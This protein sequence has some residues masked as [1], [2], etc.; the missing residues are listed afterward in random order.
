MTNLEK[1]RSLLEEDMEFFESLRPYANKVDV[2]EFISNN[3]EQFPI[4]CE[5]ITGK[6]KRT[7][8]EKMNLTAYKCNARFN[9]E[10]IMFPLLMGKALKYSKQ[11]LMR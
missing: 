8:S 2:I 5:Y 1:I 7:I 10:L 9:K 6:T 11:D 3:K 4:L